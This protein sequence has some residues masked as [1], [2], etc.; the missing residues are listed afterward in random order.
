MDLPSE[1]GLLDLVSDLNREHGTGILLVVHQIS[2][3]AGR[4]S[5]VAFVNKD[6]GLFRVGDASDLL[7][8]EGG[9]R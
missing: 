7:A 3:A 8:A 9:E 1:R 2:L 4:A 5:R 6:T